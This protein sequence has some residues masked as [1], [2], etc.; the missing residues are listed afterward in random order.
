MGCTYTESVDTRQTLHGESIF[1][2]CRYERAAVVCLIYSTV[3]LGRL[4]GIA[5]IVSAY[6]P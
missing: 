5:S 6:L 2:V 4:G 1:I 3:G